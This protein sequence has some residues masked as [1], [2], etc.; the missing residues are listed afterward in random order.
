MV[1]ERAIVT[2]ELI[3]VSEASLILQV[4]RERVIRFIWDGRLRAKKVGSMWII[5]LQDL[6]RF[7]GIPRPNGR[8]ASTYS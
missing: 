2:E 7:D 6:I 1:D 5:D 4:C 3:T 8:P